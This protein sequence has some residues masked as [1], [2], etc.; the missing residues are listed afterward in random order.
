M[1]WHEVES[2]LE[3]V[4]KEGYWLALQRSCFQLLSKANL[5]PP[6][7]T[8]Q[9]SQLFLLHFG[10][11]SITIISHH[12]HWITKQKEIWIPQLDSISSKT[13][14]KWRI[15]NIK[16]QVLFKKISVL[17]SL[18]SLFGKQKLRQFMHFGPYPVLQK[19]SSELLLS[20]LSGNTET[21]K[22][23]YLLSPIKL[24]H[25]RTPTVNMFLLF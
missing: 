8:N 13:S 15:I 17:P 11:S 12:L 18:S 1:K 4:I 14:F 24:F 6:E 16:I 3:K 19:Q 7:M 9:F 21:Y 2:I 22:S 10:V 23:T 25:L 20:Y 5:I